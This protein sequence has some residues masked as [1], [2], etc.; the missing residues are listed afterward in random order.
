MSE[1][2]WDTPEIAGRYDANCDHQYQKGL[3]LVDMM[4]IKQGDVV[5]DMG[6]GT[7]RQAVNVLT[8][9]GP[10]GSLTCVDPSS[11]QLKIT[12]EK[13]ESH[14]ITNARLIVVQCEDLSSLADAS[15]DH[16]YF[17]SSFHWIDNKKKALGEIFRVLKPGGSVGMTTMDRGSPHG[18]R[19][20]C[21]PIMD[22]YGYKRRRDDGFG[23]TK[24]VTALEL[25][26]LLS[27]AGFSDVYIDPRPIVR[28]YDT[29]D[30]FIDGKAGGADGGLLKTFRR[31]S[32]KK[33]GT[34]SSKGWKRLRSRKTCIRSGRSIVPGKMWTSKQSDSKESSTLSLPP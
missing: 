25:Y 14:G 22:K 10:S 12:R 11:H 8:I 20:I 15:F 9:I 34:R 29:P 33:S 16:A 32:G 2:D 3:T 5:L 19:D 26:D 23:S 28:H 7:G 30:K 6:C 18:M 1:I 4:K 17:C 27:D 31:T 21:D 13:L 24:R